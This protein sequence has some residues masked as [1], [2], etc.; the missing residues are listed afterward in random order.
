MRRYIYDRVIGSGMVPRASEI[1]RAVHVSEEAAIES[2][3]RMHDAHILVVDYAGEILMA[4][5]FSAVPTAFEVRSGAKRWFGNC[6]WD[7]LGILA[8]LQIDGDVRTACSDCSVPITLEIR[9]GSIAS[10]H[11]IVHFALP[12]KQWWNNIVF[13]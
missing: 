13:T 12:V 3:R 9:N 6:I 7:A 2:L 1:A 11:S 4:N 8:M 10:Q 5:P